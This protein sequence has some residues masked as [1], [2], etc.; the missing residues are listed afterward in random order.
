MIKLKRINGTEF[1]LNPDMIMQVEARPDTV[2]TLSDETKYVVAD[3]V[4]EVYDKIVQ[5]RADILTRYR[6]DYKNNIAKE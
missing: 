4:D 3:S 2:I 1:L 6:K 5:F